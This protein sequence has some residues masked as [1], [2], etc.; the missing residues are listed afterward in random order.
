MT[1][2]DLVGRGWAYPCRLSPGGSVRLLGGTDE[3]D[4]ACAMIIDTVPGE[5]VM[6]PDFGCRAWEHV[7]D[8]LTPKT[9]GL[10][11]HDV[12][13]A[14]TR[15]EPRI[16]L[17]TVE[18]RVA[19]DAGAGQDGVVLITIGYRVRATNDYRNL[20]YPFYAIPREVS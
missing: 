5:R 12:R 13:E 17:E 6:R 1:S 14:L 2:H 11:E 4:A 18:A 7:F 10:I 9:L 20:V 3:L 19:D 15:W 16:D 8:P